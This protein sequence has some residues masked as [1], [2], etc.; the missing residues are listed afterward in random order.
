MITSSDTFREGWLEVNLAGMIGLGLVSDCQPFKLGGLQTNEPLRV[1]FDESLSD[2]I[3]MF[4][5]QAST[6]FD[7]GIEDIF[8]SLI[9]KTGCTIRTIALD[10]FSVDNFLPSSQLVVPMSMDISISER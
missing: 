6:I 5:H 1:E 2:P 8:E 9:F 4:M 10:N 3:E 7:R